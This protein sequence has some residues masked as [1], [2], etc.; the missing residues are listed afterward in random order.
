MCERVI[1]N[2]L[3]TIIINKPAKILLDKLDKENWSKNVFQLK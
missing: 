1:H 3:L 2:L